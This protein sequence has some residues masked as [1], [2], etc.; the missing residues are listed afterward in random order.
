M[1]T[2]ELIKCLSNL[3]KSYYLK[4]KNLDIIS[5]LVIGFLL[6][7][8]V[9]LFTETDDYRVWKTISYYLYYYGLN[10]FDIYRGYGAVFNIVWVLD[11]PIY[12]FFS[13]FFKQSIFLERLVIKLPFIVSDVMIGVLIY[14]IMLR[15]GRNIAVKALLLWI[16]NP[17]TIW[18]SS[19]WG[20]FDSLPTL[21]TLS[22]MIMM[23]KR[24]YF[25]SGLFLAISVWLKLYPVF[26]VPIFMFTAIRNG[27]IK[28]LKLFL[29]Y[30]I[31]SMVFL[32]LPWKFVP[33]DFTITSS[34]A[35]AQNTDP[36]LSYYP[37]VIGMSKLLSGYWNIIGG[38]LFIFIIFLFLS[39]RRYTY[40]SEFTMSEEI[41]F[42]LG[43]LY[44]VLQKV[45]P[46]Y[47]IWALPFLIILFVLRKIPN[48]LFY[49][50]QIIPVLWIL[51]WNPF[52]W[53]S[54]VEAFD[55]NWIL[56]NGSHLPYSYVLGWTFSYIII[57][58]L[59][60]IFNNKPLPTI[61]GG[62]K[63]QCFYLILVIFLP[64]VNNSDVRS[65]WN[66]YK[67]LLFFIILFYNILSSLLILNKVAH[68]KNL[69]YILQIL[70]L[71]FTGYQII[72]NKE[73]NDMTIVSI[74]LLSLTPL[75]LVNTYR[76]LMLMIIPLYMSEYII[77]HSY[78][79]PHLI[80]TTS[81]HDYPEF[82][83]I[84]L[85]ILLLVVFILYDKTIFDYI[86]IIKSFSIMN[87]ISDKRMILIFVVVLLAGA[88]KSVD[89]PSQD[90]LGDREKPLSIYYLKNINETAT[91]KSYDFNIEIFNF[92]DDEVIRKTNGT[93]YI[94]METKT[95]KEDFNVIVNNKALIPKSNKTILI[96]R[97]DPFIEKDLISFPIPANILSKNMTV[98]IKGTKG[99][100]YI[101]KIIVFLY[102]D[103][104]TINPWW[105]KHKV[106]T[107]FI[108][109]IDIII[110]LIILFL[111]RI[112]IK[113]IR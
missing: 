22:S 16:F 30:F 20:M 84:N 64:W 57:I 17:Y 88:Y 9:A 98:S 13:E 85:L 100:V 36:S 26:L 52:K 83:L 99:E 35:W 8:V 28:D 61:L 4:I 29:G 10:I 2:S 46:A 82:L 54:G 23:V 27:R 49:I 103:P 73:F 112:L 39:T 92:L 93:L 78:L 40:I 12:L 89:K 62:V 104:N 95:N 24:R 53:F 42:S 72:I 63:L 65:F 18:I 91:N 77:S 41:T 56:F 69:Y 74:V 86:N 6:R 50:L 5:F 81:I 59:L 14:S 79:T 45:Y 110:V 106:F 66:N 75:L 109:L 111:A 96:I 70:P 7:S 80:L 44:I 31:L 47:I 107:S 68:N 25:L 34:S 38:F 101:D 48:W 55:T 108:I 43:I 51:N 15:S 113:N 3:L 105:S 33:S 90:F 60:L 32:S 94:K 71:V 58:L 19:I 102:N 76:F 37:L 1:N 21:F 11:Y 87:L 67:I 97:H